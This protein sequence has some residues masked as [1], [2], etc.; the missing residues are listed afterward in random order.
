VS[1]LRFLFSIYTF[2]QKQIGGLSN[3]ALLESPLDYT[4]VEDKCYGDLVSNSLRSKDIEQIQ[5]EIWGETVSPRFC[6]DTF[7]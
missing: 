7:C 6:N 3:C 4:G 1:D 2:F 5:I